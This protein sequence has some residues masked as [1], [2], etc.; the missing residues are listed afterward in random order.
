MDIDAMIEQAVT[1]AM[2]S[3]GERVALRQHA[4]PLAARERI[5]YHNRWTPDEDEFYLANAGRLSLAEIA[6]QLGRSEDAVK[7][8]YMRHGMP[9]PSK[10][11]GYLTA[12]TVSTLLGL[13][14]HKVCAW[15]D[16]GILPGERLPSVTW[17]TY[18]RVSLIRLKMWLVRPESWI[19]FDPRKI[20]NPALRSLVL[21]AQSRWGDEWLTLPEAGR[22]LAVNPKTLQQRVRRGQL[23]GI[24]S[25]NKSGR[26]A[27]G[28][29]SNW[30]VRKSDLDE[31]IIG[32][33]KGGNRKLYVWPPKADAYLVRLR[34]QGL[35]WDVIGRLMH[36]PARRCFYRYYQLTKGKS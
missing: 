19:Y 7:I 27:G 35:I 13:D 17:K 32:R 5:L 2:V 12:E 24:Q 33:G 31:Q 28:H 22:Y 18:R 8:H 34:S 15:I 10:Q 29:W 4:R 23:A 36:W 30:Y 1:D 16:A 6:R 20:K 21:R 14:N 11:P 3:N 25:R 26:H 9:A